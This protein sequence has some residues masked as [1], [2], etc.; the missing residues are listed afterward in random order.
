M[1]SAKRIL[2]NV[3]FVTVLFAVGKVE[4][5]YAMQSMNLTM[6]PDANCA[7]ADYPC[8]YT[9]DYCD[10]ENL[11]SYTDQYDTTYKGEVVKITLP[12]DAKVVFFG[13]GGYPISTQNIG[14]FSDEQLTDL[15]WD[16]NGMKSYLG[17]NTLCK[18]LTKGTYYLF[19]GTCNS[20][21]FGG[22]RDRDGNV[23][24]SYTVQAAY[25][26]LGT[27]T[28]QSGTTYAY[29][30]RGENYA[31]I[32][33]KS[34]Q[35]II[36][37]TKGMGNVQ[38]LDSSKNALYDVYRD[39][40]KVFLKKGTYYVKFD[41]VSY[42]GNLFERGYITYETQAWSGWGLSKNVSVMAQRRVPV[43]FRY[44]S[45]YTGYMT[46]SS[47]KNY[48]TQIEQ[49]DSSFKKLGKPDY[50]NGCDNQKACFVV[51]KGKTY[52]FK[53]SITAVYCNSYIQLNYTRA[54]KSNC[55]GKT[56]TAAKSKSAISGTVKGVW[57]YG[58][59]NPLWVKVKK[60]DNSPLEL[61][62]D[63]NRYSK[64]T[65]SAYDSK[66]KRVKLAVGSTHKYSFTFSKTTA[67]WTRENFYV[68]DKKGTYYL[69]IT[70]VG[71]ACGKIKLTPVKR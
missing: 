46:F 11:Y 30:G 66:G 33:L 63:L 6:L 31:K 15:V 35:N 21:Y 48:A 32:V 40:F 23:A 14:L 38:L 2:L 64:F 10:V 41:I 57:Q 53:V 12:Y 70:P 5:T 24:T 51:E 69:K 50:T 16:L 28:L 29:T 45:T 44:K 43:M 19:N 52:Y 37:T 36:L 18:N 62:L 8:K 67:G 60:T 34:N 13:V 1:K 55:W 9:V 56:R 17:S 20:D 42:F 26:L 25:L 7:V 58:C 61:K 22:W 71:G 3:L 27:N 49:Y 4:P 47:P 68:V 54:A 39:E 65:V 59:K